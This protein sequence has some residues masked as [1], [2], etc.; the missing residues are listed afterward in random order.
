MLT[1]SLQ[2]H[3][4]GRA[5]AREVTYATTGPKAREVTLR[6]A[7]RPEKLGYDWPKPE[8]LCYDQHK[9]HETF[10]ATKVA[11]KTAASMLP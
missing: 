1:S 10:F 2:G 4:G 5:Q 6:P 3:R 8:K 11:L 9:G 7:Q